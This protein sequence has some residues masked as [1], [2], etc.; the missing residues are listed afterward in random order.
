[1]DVKASLEQ[2]LDR[3]RVVGIRAVLDAYGRAPGGL[4]ANGLAFAAI[5]ATFPIAL[6]TL[7][8]AG[9]LVDDPAVQAQLAAAIG[10]LVPPLR[11]LVE[12]ALASLSAGAALTSILG[13]VS[14]V[15]T[16]SQFYVTLDVAFARIFTDRPE[17]DVLRRTARGF[18][19]V[20]GLVAAVVALIVAGALATAAEALLPAPPEAL[21]SIRLVLSSPPFLVLLGVAVVML[22]YRTVPPEAPSWRAA[23]LPASVAGIAIVILSQVFLSISAFL[24]GSTALAGP[25]ATAFIALAWLSFTFQALLYG[26]AWVRVRDDRE[27]IALS[28]PDGSALAG[29]AAAAEASSRGQ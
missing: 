13:L 5:F 28:N 23:A 18:V 25:L 20:A 15:W 4:L 1:M 9:W 29:P 3:P 24:L 16:V 11:D 6:V 17:R 21:R 10:A 22:I 26:A 19:W 8:V 2:F 14:L 27:R 12:Q 7:G